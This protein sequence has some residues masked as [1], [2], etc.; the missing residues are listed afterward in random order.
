MSLILCFMV[1]LEFIMSRKGSIGLALEV[2]SYQNRFT[3]LEVLITSLTELVKRSRNKGSFIE[4]TQTKEISAKIESAIFKRFGIRT[5]FNVNVH[6]IVG[7]VIVLPINNNHVLVDKDY[8]G[9]FLLDEHSRIVNTF[10]DKKGSIDIASAKVS[11]IFS[12]YEHKL[13]FSAWENVL[14]FNLTVEEQ[15]AIILH[16][17]GHVF[18]YY[19]LS[20]RMSRINQVLADL[21]RDINDNK[22]DKILYHYKELDLLT[23]GSANYEELINTKDRKILGIKLFKKFNLSVSTLMK[24]GKYD[25]T[26]SEQLADMFSARFG[27]SKE[28]ITGLDKLHIEYSSARNTSIYRLVMGAEIFFITWRSLGLIVLVAAGHPVIGLLHGLFSVFL[29]SRAGS[30]YKDYTYDDVKQ[31]YLRIKQQLVS[32]FKDNRLAEEEAKSLLSQLEVVDS[33]I[34]QTKDSEFLLK[35][36]ADFIFSK[37][38][39]AREDIVLQQTLEKLANSDLF[40]L[41]AKFKHI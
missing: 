20:D 18:T 31:R 29:L 22:E 19:L 13:Y 11:G 17:I 39:S 15:C 14:T 1:L 33:I 3:E 41:A 34:E 24:N 16:E 38:K 26:S 36:L 8:H 9:D 4:D 7:A 12:Q 10:N 2:I 21:N 6:P 23:E 27:Y 32:A 25:Q 5:F 37:N 40:A 35:P 28:L 30:E